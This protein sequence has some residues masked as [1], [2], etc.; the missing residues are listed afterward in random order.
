MTPAPPPPHAPSAALRLLRRFVD[1]RAAEVAPLGLGIL[2]YALLL[3]GYYILRPMRETFGIRAGS[4]QL[5]YLMLV[6]MGAS[7][8][9]NPIYSGLASRLPRSRLIPLV[10][11][12]LIVLLLVFF[13]AAQTLEGS[14]LTAAGWVF[15]IFLSVF[16]LFI[17]SVFWS[18]MADLFDRERAVRLFATLAVGGSIGALVGSSLTRLLVDSIGTG[19]L[20][21]LSALLLEMATRV[22]LSIQRR[23]QV[24]E[25]LQDAPSSTLQARGDVA[26]GGSRWAGLA[27]VWRS[28]Y[29]LGISGYMV[30]YGLSST[31]AYI[32]QGA[33]VESAA[34]DDVT[35]T[36]IF[37]NID[38]Y[39]NAVTLI[40][41]AGITAR[42][43]RWIGAGPTMILLPIYSAIGFLLLSSGWFTGASMLT[44]LMVFQVFR[45]ALGYGVAKPVREMLYTVVTPE[46]KYKAK[47]LIDVFMPRTGDAIGALTYTRLSTA[48]LGLGA[49]ALAALPVSLTWMGFGLGL[50]IAFRKRGEANAADQKA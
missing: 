41:Q 31:F 19:Y 23:F 7:M 5:P 30:L 6:V 49:L 4:D 13:V 46:Q 40:F 26:L 37:A 35:R 44:A 36:Q 48:G 28:P 8:V 43:L 1:V 16:N 17:V 25:P 21:L 34:T 33:V 32:I 29:L 12:G 11:R 47:N 45:R 22:A 10:Y 2:C 18:M 9:L 3:S 24:A 20:V 50:G 15:Y 39:T 42:L 38:F 14:A 27:E